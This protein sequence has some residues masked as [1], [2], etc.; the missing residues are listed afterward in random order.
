[1]LGRSVWARQEW[2]Y[3][4]RRG[5]LSLTVGLRNECV[6]GRVHSDPLASMNGFYLSRKQ[7]ETAVSLSPHVCLLCAG[8]RDVQYANEIC[9]VT[10]C[11]RLNVRAVCH[12][13]RRV[14]CFWEGC[15]DS[16]RGHF[17]H[18]RLCSDEAFMNENMFTVWVSP[19]NGECLEEMRWGEVRWQIQIQLMVMRMT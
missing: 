18:H 4:E 3:S 5:C 15:I 10:V 16:L 17:S 1:M 14:A 12:V 19:F 13:S 8:Q 7:E 6:I 2:K 11:C 9:C